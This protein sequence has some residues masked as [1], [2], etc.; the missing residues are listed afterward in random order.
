MIQKQKLS[1]SLIDLAE[2]WIEPLGAFCLPVEANIHMSK[3]YGYEK[4]LYGYI[5]D[6][7]AA[8]VSI[9]FLCLLEAELQKDIEMD[10]MFEIL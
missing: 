2:W 5:K 10:K 6:R 9:A 1:E 3:L 7:E 4:Y 8:H